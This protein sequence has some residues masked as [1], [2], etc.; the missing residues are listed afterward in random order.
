MM[1]HLWNMERRINYMQLCER[2][3]NLSSRMPFSAI[4]QGAIKL[5]HIPQSRLIRMHEKPTKCIVSTTN[6]IMETEPLNTQYD[7]IGEE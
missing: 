1:S 6:T 4:L 7:P 5:D 2:E 3:T